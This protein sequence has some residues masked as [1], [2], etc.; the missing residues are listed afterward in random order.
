[1]GCLPAFICEGDM[2]IR[3]YIDGFNLYHGALK[4]RRNYKW[5]DLVK[6]SQKAAGE[7]FPN[8]N[9]N[10]DLVRY[11]T[12][13][14]RGRSK[15]RQE[16]YIQAL[17]YLYINQSKIEI[18]YGSFRYR[19][20]TAK[21]VNL[22]IADNNI[23]MIGDEE[24]SNDNTSFVTGDYE[25]NNRILPIRV[26]LQDRGCSNISRALSVKASK[27]EEKRTDVN[28]A[29]H[30]LNDAWKDL[31]DVAIIMSN[32]SDLVEPIKMVIQERNKRVYVIS[33][34]IGRRI[35]RDLITC[36]TD[37]RHMHPSMLQ[38]CLLPDN[39]P[40]TNIRRPREWY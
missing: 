33:P 1:M 4:N 25:V 8:N 2:N 26:R 7:F 15:N 29:C 14:V 39:I 5:L 30:L 27:P 19:S 12:S 24:N 28:I 40:G 32:D 9:Y 21:L 38:G 22:P 31:F 6:L 10:I 35:V 18:H 13:L 3:V 36:A 37:A 34:Q 11:F 20:L 23:T 17:E 16:K